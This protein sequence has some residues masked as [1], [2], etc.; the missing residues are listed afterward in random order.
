M[1]QQDLEERFDLARFVLGYL[2]HEDSLIAPPASFVKWVT[3]NST[4]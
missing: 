1:S 4:V 2:E 3:D